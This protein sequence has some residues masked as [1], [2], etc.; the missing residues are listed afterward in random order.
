MLIAAVV[1]QTLLIAAVLQQ[2]LVLYI[3]P[4]NAHRNASRFDD[5]HHH[6]TV[7]APQSAYQTR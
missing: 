1:P 5:Y 4:S 6:S 3:H 7:S 2:D